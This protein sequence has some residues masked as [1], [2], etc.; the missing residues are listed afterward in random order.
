MRTLAPLRWLNSK[1]ERAQ[2]CPGNERGSPAPRNDNEYKSTKRISSNKWI[3]AVIALPVL[4][5]LGGNFGGEAVHQRKGERG[6]SFCAEWRSTAG[7]YGIAGR[8]GTSDERESDDLPIAGRENYLR[9]SDL[10][11]R[12][13]RM[14]TSFF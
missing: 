9:L 7:L 1:R 6:G 8:E 5:W 13:G 10:R 14:C 11:L 12:T 4:A 2:G 3:F